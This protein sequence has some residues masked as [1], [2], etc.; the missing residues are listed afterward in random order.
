MSL[1]QSRSSK[2]QKFIKNQKTLKQATKKI[3]EYNH[4][5]TNENAQLESTHN[6]RFASDETR[7]RRVIRTGEKHTKFSF[8]RAVIEFE[9]KGKSVLLY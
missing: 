8:E 5:T 1:Q 4:D 6:D 2:E 9:T 3:L 7:S